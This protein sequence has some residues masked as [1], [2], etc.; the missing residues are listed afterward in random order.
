MSGAASCR[1]CGCGSLSQGSVKKM[2]M[3]IGNCSIYLEVEDMR[4]EREI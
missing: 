1:D 3:G 2:E 4:L